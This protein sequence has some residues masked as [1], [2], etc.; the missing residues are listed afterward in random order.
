MA[1]TDWWIRSGTHHPQK[2]DLRQVYPCPCCHQGE[3]RLITLTEALGC[4]RCQ[5]IFALTLEHSH[6]EQVA[7]SFPLQKRW[8]WDGQQWIVEPETSRSHITVVIVLMGLVTIPCFLLLGWYLGSPPKD[9][10][11]PLPRSAEPHP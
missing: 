10:T 1:P 8:F 4:N 2:L 6:I 3:L 7:L 11:H 9:P 5:H